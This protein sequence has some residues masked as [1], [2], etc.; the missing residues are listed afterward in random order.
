MA[1]PPARPFLQVSMDIAWRRRFGQIPGS[2]RPGG[3]EMRRTVHLLW[4]LGL[5]LAVVPAV[6]QDIDVRKAVM[7]QSLVQQFG[8][9][10]KAAKADDDTKKAATA[11][12]RQ[13]DQA[14]NGRDY[15]TGLDQIR[16]A[17]Q[18]VSLKPAH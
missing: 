8:D 10:I 4:A 9:S 13:G 12:A 18:Q 11:L 5:G 1:A 15:D 16:Q 6:A 17:L 3:N 7:C 2:A 14:C